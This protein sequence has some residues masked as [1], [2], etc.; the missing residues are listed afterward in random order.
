MAFGK[1]T[2]FVAGNLDDVFK[3]IQ[4]NRRLGAVSETIFKGVSEADDAA[5]LLS[6]EVKDVLV[7][8]GK[9]GRTATEVEIKKLYEEAMARLKRI[10]PRIHQSHN[11]ILRAQKPG[12]IKINSVPTQQY[13]DDMLGVATTQKAAEVTK[14]GYGYVNPKR[15]ADAK[16]AFTQGTK[17]EPVITESVRTK[18]AIE[19]MY[20]FELSDELSRLETLGSDKLPK[21]ILQ[22][23][24]DA[25][26]A[27]TGK[28]LE[29]TLLDRIKKALGI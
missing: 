12:K 5:R 25:Y 2:S 28:S 8:V 22:R 11:Q 15:V 3:A 13:L 16:Y 24:K 9:K 18:D 6:G 17:V 23:R 4:K 1:I 7:K 27:F 21:E 26:I 29:P 14:N 19:R 20:K 10:K